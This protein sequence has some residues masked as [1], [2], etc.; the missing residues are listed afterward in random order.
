M[1]EASAASD[2]EAASVKFTYLS[3]D[4]EEGYPGN[5][6]VEVGGRGDRLMGLSLILEEGGVLQVESAYAHRAWYSG[7]LCPFCTESG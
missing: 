7:L 1:W 2:G 5:L 4:G 3:P 6:R